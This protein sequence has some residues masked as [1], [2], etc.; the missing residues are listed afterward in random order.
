MTGKVP[1]LIHQSSSFGLWAQTIS[2]NPFKSRVDCRCF[3]GS[4]CPRSTNGIIT[5]KMTDSTYSQ[6]W[7]QTYNQSVHTFKTLS[8]VSDIQSSWFIASLTPAHISKRHLFVTTQVAGHV[9]SSLLSIYSAIATTFFRLFNFYLKSNHLY[10][11]SL[12]RWTAGYSPPLTPI[13]ATNIR[14][15]K[16]NKHH[17]ITKG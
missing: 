6:L 12:T 16:Y 3:V 7:S 14:A 5:H 10:L 13:M 9:Q 8:T 4:R 11:Y 17:N 1:T 15:N 2:S